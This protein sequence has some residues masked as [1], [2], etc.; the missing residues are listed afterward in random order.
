MKIEERG[1]GILPPGMTL[2]AEMS[3][4][5]KFAARI[6]KKGLVDKKFE[7]DYG[8]KLDVNANLWIQYLVLK[9]VLTKG[10]PK[11]IHQHLSWLQDCKTSFCTY[12]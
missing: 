3:S 9:L 2:L 5:M 4:L 12:F 6:K 8:S 10:E 7:I 11:K 1:T